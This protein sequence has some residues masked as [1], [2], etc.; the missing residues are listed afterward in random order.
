MLNIITDMALILLPIVIIYPLQ[1]PL[2]KRVTI[3][4]L[5]TT[6]LVVIAATIAQLVYLQDWFT[7]EFTE[8][9]FSYLI[10]TEVVQFSSIATACL[11]YLQPFLESLQSGL[12]WTDAIQQKTSSLPSVSLDRPGRSQDQSHR[13]YVQIESQQGLGKDQVKLDSLPDGVITVNRTLSSSSDYEAE[14][15]AC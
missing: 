2:D 11:P 8:N 9:A 4:L 5:F 12:M 7:P 15:Q 14:N 3:I 1:M 10:C 13:I 6:R